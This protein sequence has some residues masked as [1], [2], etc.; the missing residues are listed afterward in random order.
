VHSVIFTRGDKGHDDSALS[1]EDVARIR[2][3]E[4]RAAAAILGVS[5]LTFFILRTATS[6]GPARPSPKRRHVLSGRSDRT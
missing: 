5:R 3:A 1:P 4:Q 2:E 6:V